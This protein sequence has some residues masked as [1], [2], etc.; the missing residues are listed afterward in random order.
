LVG[1]LAVPALVV[2][3]EA[4]VVKVK[5]MLDAAQQPYKSLVVVRGQEIAGLVMGQ[6]LYRTLGSLYGIPLYYQRR[7]AMLMDQKPLIIRTNTILE[8]AAELAMSRDQDKLYDDLVVV[9]E[10]GGLVGVVSVQ[11][12]LD[13]LTR[14]Q[15]ELAKGA[16]PLTGLPGNLAI[17]E[18]L[19]KRA[20]HRQISSVIYVDLDG[21]KSYNDT[22]GF[23]QGDQMILLLSKVLLH[24]MRKH[25]MDDD[26]VGHIGGDDL[27][28]I[29]RPECAELICQKIVRLFDRLVC[30][31]FS[32]ADRARRTF[33]GHDRFGRQVWL[34]LTSVSLAIVDCENEKDYK[35]LP[36]TAAQLKNRAKAEPGSL[37]V[38]D[39]RAKR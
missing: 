23:K 31:C 26:F 13:T 1:D 36:E 7:I 10:N 29:T 22:Y 20:R 4:P 8:Q 30:N 37:Y 34:P 19:S 38:R 15:I 11:R 18:E 27:I 6:N 33:Y 24:S 2:D 5:E 21:F 14:V 35:S 3:E 17:E 32:P 39:R 25:G 16:N 12:M 28:V 9:D